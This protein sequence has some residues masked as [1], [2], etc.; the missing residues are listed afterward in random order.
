[1]VDQRTLMAVCGHMDQVAGVR[2]MEFQDGRAAGLRCAMIHNGPLELPLM[3]DKCLDPAWIRYKGINLSL[4]TK[5]GLQGRNPYD[6]AGDEAVRSIMGGAMF[7]CGLGNVHG[8]RVVDGVEGAVA[9]IAAHSTG[10]SDAIVTGDE[11]AAHAFQQRVDSAA[12]YWNASTR[13]TDGG[14][15]GLGCEMGISTQKLHAR[16]PMGLGELCSY[17]YIIHGNGQTR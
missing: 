8:N 14:E 4:L 6:T 3:L 15:F 10:H 17:K 16:G 13:F 12:V 5:P 2:H 11:R 1:M 9:H 7:T